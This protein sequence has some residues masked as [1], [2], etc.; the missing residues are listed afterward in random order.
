MLLLNVALLFSCVLIENGAGFGFWYCVYISFQKTFIKGNFVKNLLEMANTLY[1]YRL[2]DLAVVCYHA[3]YLPFLYVTF[4]ADFF[5]VIVIPAFYQLLFQLHQFHN[6][7]LRIRS[8]LVQEED[9]R[10]EN[11]YYTEMKDAGFFDADWD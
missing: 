7:W 11:V 8:V 6:S 2:F 1:F 4:L 10:L 9:M 5:Q 3:L